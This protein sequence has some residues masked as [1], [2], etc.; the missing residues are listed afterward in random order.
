MTFNVLI[1]VL[2]FNNS[3]STI[4]CVESIL[5]LKKQNHEIYIVDNNS[6][7]GSFYKL[8]KH[9]KNLR[10]KK[11]AFNGGYAAGHKISV[12]YAIEN[13]FDFIWVL[14]NDL[15]VRKNTLNEL[16]KAYELNGLG[17]YGSI[18]LKSE[19]PDIVN[20]GGGNTN[21]ISE[22]LDYNAYENTVLEEYLK[23][24]SL[25]KVQ[26]VEG[27]SMLIPVKVIIQY[28]FMRED[29][30]MYGEETDYCYKLRKKNIFSYVVPTSIVV[31]K[32]SETFKDSKQLEIYYRRR[33]F[34]YFQKEHYKIPV[35]K[36]IDKRFGFFNF[37][38]YLIKCVVYKTEKDNQYF[39]NIASLHSLI[40]KKGKYK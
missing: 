10:V 8:K 38:K 9:F 37:I 21:D 35:I 11:S 31:H 23:K 1:S 22:P 19:N 7:D 26:S 20:F 15:T 36:N 6:T 39:L 27:S 13:G 12:N 28:G 17:I 3:L 5:V 2:N 18:T 29:F 24:T 16:I 30:F 14:N 33:N 4:K 25:R 40:G 32:G 34:L